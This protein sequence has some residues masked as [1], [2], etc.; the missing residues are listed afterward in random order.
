MI[1][2]INTNNTSQPRIS[3]VWFDIK[4][5]ARHT[6]RYFPDGLWWI[7]HSFVR[8]L[9]SH[10]N[11]EHFA[12]FR[13]FLFH[14]SSRRHICW[15]RRGWAWSPYTCATQCRRRCVCSILL[16]LA[17]STMDQIGRKN[18]FNMTRFYSLTSKRQELSSKNTSTLVHRQSFTP[19]WLP[20]SL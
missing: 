1:R 16:F 10:W 8:A 11:C 20:I 6:S 17:S 14:T 9:T 18:N 3:G 2:L 13:F 7:A 15:H 12:A 19:E 5:L 4:P